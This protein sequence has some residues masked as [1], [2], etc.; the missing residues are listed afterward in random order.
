M[1]QTKIENVDEFAAAIDQFGDALA[2][3]EERRAEA[4]VLKQMLE[5]YANANGINRH[6]TDRYVLS[7]KKS[8][9][10]LRCKSGITADAVV[11]ALQRSEVGKAY[12][13]PSYDAEAL[14]RDFGKDDAGLEQLG[15]F[16]LILTEPKRH[17]EVKAL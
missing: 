16:G 12:V 8:G 6:K 7:L 13:V 4:N 15:N 14:K 11:A 9:A 17:A 3:I 2:A 1:I 10:A 5:T